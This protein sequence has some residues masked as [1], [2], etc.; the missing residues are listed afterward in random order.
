M[1]AR[2][3]ARATFADV[4]DYPGPGF[5]ERVEAGVAGLARVDANAAELLRAFLDRVRPMRP[6]EVEELYTATFDFRP[7]CSLHAGWHLFGDDRRRSLF[8]V[9]LAERYRARGLSTGKELPDHLP[10]LFRFA[11]ASDADTEEIV[12]E[13]LVP[14]LAAIGRELETGDHPYRHA[15]ASALALLRTGDPSRRDGAA[16]SPAGDGAVAAHEGG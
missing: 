15:I 12:A 5:C 10:L 3:A 11:A 14:A 2:D 1:T 4:L 16:A 6:G 9:G 13:A 8:L 7:R